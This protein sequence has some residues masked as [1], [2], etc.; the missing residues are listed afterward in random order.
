MR[1][2]AKGEDVERAKRREKQAAKG[3]ASVASRRW[4]SLR[5]S[6]VRY[7]QCFV[8]SLLAHQPK[9]PFANSTL[10]VADV[11]NLETAYH[12]THDDL[13]GIKTCHLGQYTRIP[14]HLTQV[15]ERW[16]F[17]RPH[18]FIVE[19]NKA[20]AKAQTQ[21]LLVK[22]TVQLQVRMCEERKDVVLRIPPLL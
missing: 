10:T 21:A 9:L 22:Q 5:S 7:S 12:L 11:T 6:A 19:R 14:A 13:R 20:M 1:R 15:L 16:E 8:A 2:V 3:E 4:A 17:V 18:R